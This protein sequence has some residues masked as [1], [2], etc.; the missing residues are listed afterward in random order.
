MSLDS[1]NERWLVNGTSLSQ[2]CWAVKTF[3][4]SPRA[5]PTFRGQDISVAYIPGKIFRSKFPDSRVV[6]LLMWVAGI[7][8]STGQ[9]A[10]DTHLQFSDNLRTLHS[11]I[12]TPSSQ[13]QLTREWRYT[14]SGT[15]TI[16]SATAN[17][18]IA[19]DAQPTMTAPGRADFSADFLLADPYF[20]GS[21]VSATVPYNSNTTVTN[22]GDDVVAY[23]NFTLTFHGPLF[24][25]IL[26][27]T[28]NLA[29]IT[30]NTLI[31]L[32]DSITVDVAN[33]QATHS[34]GSDMRGVVQHSASR[35]WMTFNTGA[36]VLNLSSSLS[37]DSGTVGV[38]FQPP[39]V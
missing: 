37:T 5:L 6:S 10:A 24:Y 17:A 9:P 15:P 35:R 4:G 29:S 7:V 13:V 19:G 21:T 33:Y 18:Q 11:L 12:Y 1:S 26:T 32:G 23:N 14:V 28:T 38:S 8:P 22:P 36:N 27:N 2:Y 3:G 30:I 20:Y 34:N 16:V 25:P 39:Y 31:A